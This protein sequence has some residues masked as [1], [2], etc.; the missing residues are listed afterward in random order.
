MELHAIIPCSEEPYAVDQTGEGYL[1]SIT[2]KLNSTDKISTESFE[3]LE[4]IEL[5]H[6]PRT[7]KA[8]DN[9]AVLISGANKILSTVLKIPEFTKLVVVGTGREKKKD[10]NIQDYGGNNASGHEAWLYDNKRFFQL[11]RIERKVL[12]FDSESEENLW[13]LNTPTTPHHVLQDVKISNRYYIVCEGN[14]VSLVPPSLIAVDI[15]HESRDNPYNVSGHIFLPVAQSDYKL[16][17]GHHVD[18]QPDGTYLYMGSAEGYCYIINSRT[19]EVVKK[20]PTGKGHGHTG[21]VKV[22]GGLIA[23]AINHKD[24]CLTLIDTATQEVIEQIALS[25]T[26]PVEDTIL[27]QG[28]TTGN[29][30]GKFYIMVSHEARFVEIDIAKRKILRVLDLKSAVGDQIPKL[31]PLQGTFLWDNSNG[32]ICTDCH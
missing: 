21:F 28:H 19:L 24:L 17:G 8:N 29:L 20:L 6:S 9:D 32:K 26:P 18:Q 30:D 10:E 11:D 4:L 7:A 27:T 22:D 31:L 16:M 12:V 2:R 25:N 23:V 5:D 14:R 13:E 3:S 15:N 1:L